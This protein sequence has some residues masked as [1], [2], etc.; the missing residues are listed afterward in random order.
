[1]KVCLNEDGRL[2]KNFPCQL[3]TKL[4]TLVTPSYKTLPIS[5]LL[6]FISTKYRNDRKRR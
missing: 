6:Y 4:E 2:T 1:M 5:H 3:L